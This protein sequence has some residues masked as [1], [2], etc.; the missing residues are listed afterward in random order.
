MSLATGE[1]ADWPQF[2]G[3][4]R[5]G[6]YAGADLAEVWPKEGPTKIWE[7]QIGQGFSGPV[8][9][10]GKLILFHRVGDNE[11]VECLDSKSAKTIWKFDYPT[12]YR[13]DFG[14]D[15]GPRATPS[16]SDG[17][18]YT[19]GA[20]GVLN[21][22]DLATG[23]KVWNVNVKKEL[24]AP[25]GFFGFACSPLIEGNCVLLNVGGKDGAGIVAFDKAN[26][27]LL[28]KATDDGASYSSPVSATINGRRCAL[29]LTLTGLTAADP[30]SGKVVWQFPFR[31]PSRTSVSAATPVVAGDLVFVSTAYGTGAEL[32]KM[33]E[34]GATKVWASDD[35]LSAHYT[36]SVHLNGFLYGIHGRTDPSFEPASLR[37]IDFKT[38]KIR[39]E[40]KS[41]GAATLILA[42][43]RLLI[44]TERGELI[45]APA[46]P[47][48]FKVTSRAQVLP[49]Q[50]R[51]Y[52]ALADGFFYARSK[53]KLVCLNL[54]QNQAN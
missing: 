46:S 13:D 18:V 44:L 42:G 30:S 27:K 47:D 54:R 41:F 3:P 15:E 48:G 24:E 45:L 40:Q 17:K 38:G 25:K 2:L 9:V 50:V 51:A 36:T 49:N 12:S 33:S 6:V 14:F 20:E 29:F 43:E 1:A 39:W 23:S 8:V 37:C 26:G 4:T 11:V 35:V 32:L 19:F 5:N 10:A 21:C 52:P 16:V 7:K 34:A 53:D 28:W 31:P 22:E